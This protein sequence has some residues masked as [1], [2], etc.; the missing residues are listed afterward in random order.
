MTCFI[1]SSYYNHPIPIVI[2]RI[3]TEYR[4]SVNNA[5]AFLIVSIQLSVIVMMNL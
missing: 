5:F 4:M 3:K 2:T 1:K